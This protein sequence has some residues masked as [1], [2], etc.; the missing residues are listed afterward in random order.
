MG[1]PLVG[2]DLGKQKTTLVRHEKPWQELN[3]IIENQNKYDTD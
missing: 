3:R 1:Y 2:W